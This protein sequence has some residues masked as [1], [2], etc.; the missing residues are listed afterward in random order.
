MLTTTLTL[1]TPDF[2]PA[3]FSL[4]VGEDGAVERTEAAATGLPEAVFRLTYGD[5]W[6]AART[7]LTGLVEV[8]RFRA[9]VALWLSDPP[10]EYKLL[11]RAFRKVYPD[12]EPPGLADS[13]EQRQRVAWWL[14]HPRLHPALFGQQRAPAAFRRLF[15][16]LREGGV[17][18]DYV[19]P[20]LFALLP[21]SPEVDDRRTVYRAIGLL[22]TERARDY[23]FGELEQAGRHPYSTALLRALPPLA[24]PD[25][26]ARVLNLYD[27]IG[28]ERELMEDYLLLLR[29][30]PA[31]PEVFTV[32]DR[33]LDRHPSEAVYVLTAL[34]ELGHPTPAAVIRQR[35]DRE[36]DPRLLDQLAELT[37]ESD[38]PAVRVDLA[39]MNARLDDP[40]FTAAAPVTWP[41]M[42]WQHW[43]HLLDEAPSELVLDLVARYLVRPEPLLQR[44]AL[45]QLRRWVHRREFP[46]ALPPVVEER[47]RELVDAR[48]DK[49]S[50]VAVDILGLTMT[51][52]ADPTAATDVLLRHS[53]V[54]RYKLMDFAALKK[55]ATL[56]GLRQRQLD[57]FLREITTAPTA[58]RLAQLKRTL[59]YLS[60]LKAR[61]ELTRAVADRSRTLA[62]N[63]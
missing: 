61:E 10:A 43:L 33:I 25:N 8:V 57:Y 32:I 62:A 35:F 16:L 17:P 40:A 52:L 11:R 49:I 36:T 38:D 12:A 15:A 4:S 29:R 22:G 58:E 31:G 20:W 7:Y 34:R 9:E 47:L 48:V 14:A 5:R 59:P 23:L 30:L 53:L 28:A 1:P 24:H 56:P 19:A 6:V 21:V 51:S 55:S 2:G 44:N 41:Q 3:G 37:A 54:S 18:T 39:T 45:L 63:G 26:Q 60:Y 42:L 46:P 50:T 13:G 27:R